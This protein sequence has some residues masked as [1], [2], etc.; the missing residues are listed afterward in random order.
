MTALQVSAAPN[1]FQQEL[2]LLSNI[3]D[4]QQQFDQLGLSMPNSPL[5][6]DGSGMYG[7][8]VQN[9]VAPA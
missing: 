8:Y 6:N 5:Q 3:A 9:F 7:I 1:V 4:A 2:N